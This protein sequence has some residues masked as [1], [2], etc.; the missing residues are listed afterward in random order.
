[1]ETLT[2]VAQV[3][4]WRRATAG[5]VGLVPTMGCLHEGHLSL[6]AAA[7]RG[8]RAPVPAGSP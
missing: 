3:R 7:R 2:K 8:A 5:T 1:M 6:V 4:A